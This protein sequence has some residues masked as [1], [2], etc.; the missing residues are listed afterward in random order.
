MSS[1]TG[2]KLLTELADFID[3][4]WAELCAMQAFPYPTL[5]LST[6]GGLWSSG[7]GPEPCAMQI[8]PYPLLVYLRR[9]GGWGGVGESAK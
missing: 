7:R 9:G 4:A 3:K 6:R 5:D 2:L 1:T 8:A